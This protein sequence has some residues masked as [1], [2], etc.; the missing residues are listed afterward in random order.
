MDKIRSEEHADF[1][2]EKSALDKGMEGVKMALK[3]LRDYYG[4]SD[5]AHQTSEGAGDNIISLLETI[6]SDFSQ[7]L[8]ELRAGEQ[9]AL[10][11]YDTETQD[12]KVDKEEKETQVEHKTKEFTS[13]DKSVADLTSDRAGVQSELDAVVEYLAKLKKECIVMPDSYEERKK[14][15]EAEIAGLKDA[16]NTLES[17][18]ALI[19]KSSSRRV[20]R[21][22]RQHSLS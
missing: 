22:S 6:E 12:N 4:K 19:Q 21:G 2:D 8:A 3:T 17:E 20:L 10:S 7:S 16:L 9:R 1:L 18:T 15:R 14:R 11:D 5:K 13:L